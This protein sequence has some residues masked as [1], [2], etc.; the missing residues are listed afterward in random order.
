MAANGRRGSRSSCSPTSAAGSRPRQRRRH[1]AGAGHLRGAAGLGGGR[2][3]AARESA[4]AGLPDP[5]RRRW[6]LTAV[7]LRVDA[8][9]AV[10][11]ALRG[12][13][14]CAI[15]LTRPVHYAIL[16][17]L[18]ETP[19][20]LTASNSASGMLEGLAVF[21]GPL[22]AGVAADARWCGGGV[23]GGLG[24]PAASRSSSRSACIGPRPARRRWR[25]ASRLLS[26]ALEGLRELRRAHAAL[27]LTL[28]V[29]ACFIV[30]GMLDVLTVVLA[31]G[32][33]EDVGG[34]SQHPDVGV[35]RRRR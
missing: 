14:H 27:L 25:R 10:I 30:I 5:G 22:P 21:V 20:E 17:E 26:G 16:P 19:P 7:A 23:R 8:P 18:A 3:D 31:L 1:H 12:A 6:A 35:G 28:L 33:P 32:R 9:I 29:G 11:Y 15:T 2:Q 24:R 34:G 4:G 13:R